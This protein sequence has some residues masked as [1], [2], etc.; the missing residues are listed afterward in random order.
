MGR[1]PINKTRSPLALQQQEWVRTI[2]AWFLQE[3]IAA[4][5][6]D[7][8][9][10]KLQV[11]KATLYKYYASKEDILDEVV[12]TKL[13]DIE[14]FEPQLKDDETGF[15]ERYFE[16]IKSAAV[17]LAEFSSQFLQDIKQKYPEL[18]EKI[19]IFQTRALQ[20]GERFYQ[21]GIERGILRDTLNPRL[22][23]LM[24][25][26]FIAAAANQHFLRECNLQLQEAV[27]GFYEMKS[28]GIFK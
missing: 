13:G 14:A 5:T 8:I 18:W 6:M 11:S 12:R 26:I 21:I 25:K 10:A 4:F 22:L 3:G 2:S 7:E 23:A 28:K 9:A 15:T 24:D 16:V 1:K 19:H 27:D 17:M 20:A